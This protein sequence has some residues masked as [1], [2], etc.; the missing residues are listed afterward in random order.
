MFCTHCGVEIHGEAV[1]CVNCGCSVAKN[2][3]AVLPTET[4]SSPR[5]IKCQ[6]GLV[7]IYTALFDYFRNLR[8]SGYVWRQFRYQ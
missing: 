3:A 1:I 5:S 2:T 7:K 8:F 4:E 6:S